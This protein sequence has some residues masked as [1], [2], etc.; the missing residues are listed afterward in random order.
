MKKTYNEKLNSNGDL[1]KIVDLSTKK[2]YIERYNAKTMLVAEPSAYNN[3]IKRLPDKKLITID[4]IRSYLAK[5]SKADTTCQLT[6][7][8]FVN[9]CAHAAVERSD[10]AFPWWRVLK[11]DGEL[12]EKY[13]GGIE[14][15]KILLEKEKFE[16]IKKGK[17]YFVKDFE[18][19][20]WDI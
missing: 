19:N 17:K 5:E 6:A 3:I 13:P 4:R 15:Q 14:N 18:R 16:V 10:N 8:I 2:G 7:G 1:P 12:N 11:K 20:I 9:V